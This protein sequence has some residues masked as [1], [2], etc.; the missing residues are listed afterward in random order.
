MWKAG[1]E[2]FGLVVN[3]TTHYMERMADPAQARY[4]PESCSWCLEDL[5]FH[6]NSPLSLARERSWLFLDS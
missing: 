1:K 3:H 5:P 4:T 6:N 2:V